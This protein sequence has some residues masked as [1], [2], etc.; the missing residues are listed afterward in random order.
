MLLKNSDYE[1]RLELLELAEKQFLESEIDSTKNPWERFSAALGMAEYE[2]GDTA[3]T[4]FKRAD[5]NM[6][7]KKLIAKKNRK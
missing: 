6:Y 5:K 2:S 1:N 3:E 4:V 7:D